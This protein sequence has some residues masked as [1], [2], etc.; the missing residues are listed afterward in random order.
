MT[1]PSRSTV[2]PRLFPA[3]LLAITLAACGGGGG[4]ASDPGTGTGDSSGSAPLSTADDVLQQVSVLSAAVGALSQVSSAA[5]SSSSS[6]SSVASSATAQPKLLSLASS[7]Q[8]TPNADITPCT[9]GTSVASSPGTKSYSFNYVGGPN[10]NIVFED[11]TFTACK[12]SKTEDGVTIS[13]TLDGVAEGGKTAQS[14]SSADYS[15]FV[16]GS[17]ST[18]LQAVVQ[19]TGTQVATPTV[20]L[21][22]TGSTQKKATST[23]NTS[24]SVIELKYAATAAGTTAASSGTFDLGDASVQTPF[25]IAT[26]VST[27][28]YTL[29][30]PYSYSTTRCT[31]GAA[32]VT[33]SASLTTAQ[34]DST[35]PATA[36][37]NG[38]AIKITTASASGS[39]TFNSDGSASY[40]LSNGLTGTLSKQDIENPPLTA[41]CGFQAP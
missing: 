38:G 25:V 41:S 27:S 34:D 35:S 14:V 22:I 12:H 13:V 4:N 24:G 40:V 26:D 16:A 36:Y 20:T 11:V 39:I 3:T 2:F 17:G 21:D 9:S 15:Y 29:T 30:G 28:S 18:P 6:S 23:L 8:A 37:V 33:T 1:T 7:A 10:T 19:A 32:S 5:D 31:G